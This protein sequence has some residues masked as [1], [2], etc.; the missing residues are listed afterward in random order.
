MWVGYSFVS[1]MWIH[2]QDRY[3]RLEHDKYIYN[4]CTTE[5]FD[6]TGLGL[7]V[8]NFWYFGDVADDIDKGDSLYD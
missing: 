1:E 6:M 2:I 8:S 7:S 3:K 4:L 5:H